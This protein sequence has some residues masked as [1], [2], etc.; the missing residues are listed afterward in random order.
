MAKIK[1]N[2]T[3]SSTGLDR[4]INRAE[5]TRRDNDT[6]KIPKCSIYDVDYAILSYIREVIRPQ[7]IEDQLPVAV[8]AMFANAEKYFFGLI[9]FKD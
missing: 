5:Q 4:K 9:S 3:Y 2:K 7:V 1:L 6:V 8:P